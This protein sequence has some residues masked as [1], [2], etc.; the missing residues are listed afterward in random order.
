MIRTFRWMRLQSLCILTG[1]GSFLFPQSEVQVGY[2]VL[3]ADAGTHIPVAAALF[4]VT[5][6]SG[7]LVSQAGV[8][9]VEPFSS[10]RIFVDQAKTETGIALVNPSSQTASISLVLRDPSGTEVSRKT[11]SL[12]AGKH[13]PRFVSQ[14]FT[15]LPAGFSGSLTFDSTQKLAAIT[16]RES[17]NAQNELFYTTLPVIDLSKASVIDPIAFPQIAAGDGYTTQL[18]LMN[19]TAQT[20]RGQISLLG[21]D[22]SPLVLTVAGSSNS[23]FAYEVAPN[24]TYRIELDSPAGLR[25]G[26]AL[27]TPD[28]GYTSPTGSAVFR[29]SRNGSLVTEAGVSSTPAT[30]SARIY[31]D[32]ADSYTGVAIAN[33]EDQAATVTFSLVDKTGV[34]QDS[35]TRQLKRNGHLAVFA[36]ELFPGAGN[37]FT[38]LI[39]IDST[40]P[41]A[42]VTLKLTINQRQDLIYTTLPVADLNR[43]PAAS[44]MIFPQ[45]A[46]GG[47]FSTRLIF[48]STDKTKKATGKL[49]FYRSDSGPLVLPLGNRTANEFTYEV[50]Q[51]GG[52]QFFPGNAA[53]LASIA[54]LNGETNQITGEI[55]VNVGKTVKASLLALDETGRPRDDFVFSYKSLDQTVATIDAG[56]IITG[57]EAGFSTLTISA[58][59]VLATGT[60]TV[61]SVRSG[62]T[63]YEIKGVAQDLAR[64]LYLAATK[65]HMILLA[66]DLGQAAEVYAGTKE[67]PGLKNDERLKSQFRNP[68]FLAFDQARGTLYVS[69]GANHVIRRVQPGPEGKV[70]TL[71][72]TGA[73]GGNDGAV[74]AATFNNPQ[75]IT[76]DNRG[77]LWVVDT[78]N[79]TIRR[80]NLTAGTVETIAGS[81]G[82]AGWVDGTGKAAKFNSPAG[83]ALETEPLAQQLERERKGDPPPPVSMIIADTG[84]GL[85][86]RVRESGAVET[87]RTNAQ[88][89]SSGAEISSGSDWKGMEQASTRFK[90]PTG[91]TVD[92]F[93]NIYI[94]EPGSSRIQ[95]ILQSGEVVSAAGAKTFAAPTG[96]VTTQSGKVLVAD[97]TSFA[98][99]LGY[100]EPQI[101]SVTP[102]KISLRGGETVTIT[103][104]NFGP[105][106]LI[107]IAGQIINTVQS[108]NSNALV[109]TAPALASGQTTLTVQNRAGL[110]QKSFVI[111]T[112]SLDQLPVGHIT[113]VAG[114]S[115]YS[116]D[117]YVASMATLLHPLFI[118]ID[119]Q[120]NLYISDYEDNRIRKVSAITGIITSIAG[121][122]DAGY[123]GDNGPAAAARLNCPNG[124]AV[125]TEGNLLVAD[126]ANA[127]IRKIAANTGIITTI[128]GTGSHGFSGDNGPA[129]AAKLS[130]PSG[131]AVDYANNIFINDLSNGR[132]RKVDATKGIITTVAGTGENGYSGD[133]GPATAARL[134]Y[135]Q[136]IALDSIGNLLISDQGNYRIRKVTAASGIIT[137]VAGNGLWGFSGDNGPA[138]AAR[139]N[140]TAGIAVDSSDNILIADTSNQ[141]I[142][143]VTALTGIITTVAGT[144]EKGYS[145]D[146]IPAISAKLNFPSG[147]AADS[148]GN[149]LLVDAANN[150]VRK[151]AAASGIIT[152]IAGNGISG[153]LGDNGPATAAR[154]KSPYAVAL[155]SSGNL[156]ISDSG[157]SRIRMVAANS[158]TITTVAGTGVQGYSGD[159]GPATA[160]SLNS[161][162]GVAVNYD[163]NIF[164]ADMYNHRIRKVSVATG[165]IETVAG[166]GAS[167]YSG[168]NGLATAA[169]ISMPS[170]IAVDSAGNL[171]IADYNN[172]RIRKVSANAGIIE[173]L[174]GNGGAGYSGD[175][176]PAKDAKLCWPHGIAVDSAGNLF[177]ADTSNRRVRKVSAA[178][179][180]ITTVA[181]T[182]DEGYSG[183]NG[184]AAT[185]MLGSPKGIAV[186]SAGNLFISDGP[187]RIRKV[188]AASGIITTI[189][190]TGDMGYSGDTQSALAAR[191]RSPG[192]IVVSTQGNIYFADTGNSRIRAIRGPI[193]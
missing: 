36:H 119:S 143:K 53:K 181:G 169:K 78:G 74:S 124:V 5:N 33:R 84:N 156:Y 137:T 72:G 18:I 26:Y 179:G 163:G 4:S 30:T 109:F 54:L 120:G 188:S 41:M 175:N 56:G 128:A 87:I 58:G 126:S 152:T 76:L 32:N 136:G 47:G 129:T 178:T 73:A 113:T 62:A 106:T 102:E 170:A 172:N 23:R 139:V 164:I 125:D 158:G 177:I 105:G 6:S 83:I 69:D 184:P 99:E 86:R 147:V 42:A 112:I 98:R 65:S 122:G 114:G 1:L 8:G 29:Y 49:S 127:R 57:K 192:G 61:V 107:I 2:A 51:D 145:G 131:V 191:L 97:S 25:G 80:I 151:V 75:G 187:S 70:D 118:A 183:D 10:G 121:T 138:T 160:A 140:T 27:V 37:L 89:V 166:T 60:I 50:A 95:T 162:S 21:D 180:I 55:A 43:V 90:S 52:V 134:L 173:T 66:Q 92:P 39:Q 81:L 68:A 155:A 91:V 34:L 38:G 186:D 15:S 101:T 3:L 44:Q 40:T 132:I 108:R 149:L 157:H 16:L 193:P 93:G 148:A 7:I 176:G 168:D 135:P 45:I 13:L 79:H 146:G 71:A 116:G 88:G 111:G 12:D 104:K 165:I 59:E 144:G 115:T 110:A 17:V 100:G 171:L 63:G 190:G 35:V 14:I 150:R 185:A 130:S 103:G 161:P 123:W 46:I 189:A 48:I 153:Y 141:R 9:A 77:N 182:G 67:V 154:F 117:G 167:G 64:R 96:I 11:I 142:R 31:V 133:G 28:A 94:S 24:G 82:S 85:I 174:A 159:N 19:C 20:Q 22:G